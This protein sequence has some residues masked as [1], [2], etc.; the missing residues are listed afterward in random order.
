MH[1]KEIVEAV[2]IIETPPLIVIGV[3]G[4]I[5][6]PRGLRTIGTVWAQHISDEARRRFYRRWYNSKKKAF[7]R[8][9]KKYTERKQS[10]DAVLD[11]IKKYA[12]VVRAIAHTQMRKV[13]L[14]QKKAH[15]AEIQVNGGTAAD[16]VII[17]A[18]SILITIHT[19]LYTLHYASTILFSNP[20]SIFHN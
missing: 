15:I 13:H 5:E 4:Y 17:L 8:Y 16:K 12:K 3:V 19:H 10:I 2:T 6:T 1:K 18:Y 20:L 14:T 9:S 7:T 11:K